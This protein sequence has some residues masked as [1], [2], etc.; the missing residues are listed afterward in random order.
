MKITVTKLTSWELVADA[1][2]TTV[3]RN[4]LGHEPS[5][6]FKHDVLD[7]EHSPIRALMFAIKMEG[8]PT[9]ASVHL[10]RHKQ[11]VENFVSSNRP[12]RNGGNTNVTRDTP[13]NHLMIINAQALMTISRRRLCRMASPE[14]REVWSAVVAELAKIDPI[15]AEY[16]VPM[17]F[18][19]GGVCHEPNGCGLC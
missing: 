17:C 2:R 5:D 6:K 14:T 7:S 10:V 3:W 4:A 13:V 11:G 9:S 18:Y 19:R 8:I 15:V 16:C 12:D 1:A